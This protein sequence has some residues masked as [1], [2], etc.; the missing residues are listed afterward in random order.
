MAGWD[1]KERLLRCELRLAVGNGGLVE[2]D[3]LL[4]PPRPTRSRP[5]LVA[6]ADDENSSPEEA[7]G[8]GEANAA[9][10]LD[11]VDEMAL[12]VL[13]VVN[14]KRAVDVGVDVGVAVVRTGLDPRGV[15]EGVDHLRH[16]REVQSGR[17]I[18]HEVGHKDMRPQLDVTWPS[19]LKSLM[20]Q[21]WSDVPENRPDFTVRPPLHAD[22][23]VCA[24]RARA[25]HRPRPR[26][27]SVAYGLGAGRV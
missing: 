24:A 13:V 20:R 12:G 22:A 15:L 1:A 7:K 16:E 21:C 11:V 3:L 26:P 8:D 5:L 6:A 23:R 27:Q 19:R 9:V 2:G 25:R 14:G 18:L 4:Q 17:Q 10:A